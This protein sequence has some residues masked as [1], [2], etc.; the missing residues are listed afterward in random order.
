MQHLHDDAVRIL[1]AW[2]PPDP[3]QAR[4]RDEYL[5]FM[6]AHRNATDRHCRVGHLTAS[7]LVVNPERTAVLLTLHPKVGRWLQLG[8]HIEATDASIQA[9][10][11]REAHEESGHRPL[12]ISVQPVRLDRHP[13]PCGDAPAEHL[14]V[15]FIATVRAEARPVRSA[16]SV[17][18]AWFGI[19]AVPGDPS[20]LALV[21][22]MRAARDQQMTV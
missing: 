21:Q 11:I 10:A 4:L 2:H 16:E 14:D 20:V 9:A 17:D 18:V 19:D 12:S 13:V 5:A 1:T 7:T 15:Q 22:A 3:Q 8:G 6:S